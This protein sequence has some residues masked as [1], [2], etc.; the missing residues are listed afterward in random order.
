MYVWFDGLCNPCDFDYQ[1]RLALGN[2]KT[3]SLKDIWNG[4][5]FQTLRKDHLAGNRKEHH[6]CDVCTL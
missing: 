6:P 1:S 2:A 4:E 3:H 5:A